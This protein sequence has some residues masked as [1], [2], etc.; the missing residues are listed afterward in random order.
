MQQQ[1]LIPQ[2]L[3]INT[4]NTIKDNPEIFNSDLVFRINLNKDI[5]HNKPTQPNNHVP[6]LLNMETIQN[7]MMSPEIFNEQLVARIKKNVI[8]PNNT[9]NVNIPKAKNMKRVRRPIPQGVGQLGM[10]LFRQSFGNYHKPVYKPTSIP[11]PILISDSEPV[12]AS[13]SEPILISDSDS[14]SEQISDKT[15]KKQVKF[16]FDRYNDPL[17]QKY[18]K[19][20]N[21]HYECELCGHQTKCR[22]SIIAHRN[23]K[24]SLNHIHKYKCK[25]CNDYKTDFKRDFERHIICKHPE[26][27]FNEKLEEIAE[28]QKDQMRNVLR[29]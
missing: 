14:E 25:L 7:I 4:I 29:K 22:T 10:E 13:S 3:P 19:K 18:Y 15:D 2:L 9:F 16:Q 1:H 11:E 6:F 26:H 17:Y 24:H 21:D 20:V 12:L 8:L 5:L 28:V 27:K 23:D